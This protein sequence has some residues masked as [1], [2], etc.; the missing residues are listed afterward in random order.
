MAES[1][2][3][4]L[5][6]ALCAANAKFTMNGLRYMIGHEANYRRWLQNY[7]FQTTGLDWRTVQAEI[8]QEFLTTFNLV[9][10]QETGEPLPPTAR[11]RQDRIFAPV[12]QSSRTIDADRGQHP[13]HLT[14]S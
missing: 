8:R 4:R 7:V 9:Y 6:H 1:A 14:F 13:A 10:M 11:R 12:R 3:L 2:Y 5:G